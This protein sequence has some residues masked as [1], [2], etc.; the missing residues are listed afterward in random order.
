MEAIGEISTIITSINDYQLTIASA[1]EEQTATTNEMSRNVAEASSG[2]GEIAANIS[3][4]SGAAQATT[5]A[6]SQSRS[7]IDEMA[8]MSAELRSAVALFKS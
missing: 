5:Q 6:L 4:V 2:S 1:V 8:R 3:G 7:A